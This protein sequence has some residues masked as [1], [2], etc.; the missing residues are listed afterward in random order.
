MLMVYNTHLVIGKQRTF[1]S[2]CPSPRLFSGALPPRMDVRQHRKYDSIKYIAG[3]IQQ[4]YPQPE[5][6]GGRSVTE[7]EEQIKHSQ[8]GTG[9]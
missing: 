2:T 4:E 9:R 8:R 7:S 5:L 1:C 6:P 3:G